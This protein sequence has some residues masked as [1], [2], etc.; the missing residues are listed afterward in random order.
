[1]MEDALKDMAT[2][3]RSFMHMKLAGVFDRVG[4]IIPGR[5]E[6]FRDEG[7]GRRPHDILLEVLGKPEIPIPAEFDCCHTHP[8]LTLPLGCE[9]KLDAT[10]QSVTL[11]SEWLSR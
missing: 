4:G 3:E 9:V 1:M 2:V 8:M 6:A 11:L 7:S 10:A 5:H